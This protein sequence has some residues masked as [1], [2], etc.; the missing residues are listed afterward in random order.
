MNSDSYV[1]LL[2]LVNMCIL[3]LSD[4]TKLR[5]RKKKKSRLE[6][7]QFQFLNICVLLSF[8]LCIDCYQWVTVQNDVVS[9]SRSLTLFRGKKNKITFFEAEKMA[10]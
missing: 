3:N 1:N 7:S 8:T 4:K 5:K 2:Q 10:A 9:V 6:L